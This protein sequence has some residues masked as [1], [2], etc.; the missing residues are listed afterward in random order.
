MIR[1]NI[2][3]SAHP[4]GCAAETLRQIEYVKAR[5]PRYEGLAL[6][7]AVLVIGASGGYGLASRIAAAFGCGAATVG[8]SLEREPSD[9]KT[10][11]PGWYN[12]NAFDRAAEEAGLAHRTMNLDAFSREAKAEAVKAARELGIAYDLV[13]YSLASPVRTDPSTGIMH[14]S[15]IKPIG[16]DYSGTTVDVFTGKLSNATVGPATEEECDETVK[17]MGG[18][19]WE[20]WIQALKEGG[21]LADG[22]RTVAYSYIGP[23][24]SWPIY[25]DGTLGRAKADL[26][27][28]ARR[29]TQ[30]MG[31]GTVPRVEAYVSVNKAVV[32]RASAV[33][34]VIPL[35]V[36]VLFRVMKE[37]RNHEDCIAQ[38]DRLFRERLCLVVRHADRAAQGAVPAAAAVPAPMTAAAPPPTDDE[39][40]IRMDDLEMSP[41]VQ[42]EVEAA[43]AHVT[44]ETLDSLADLEGFRNDFLS[45]H[46]FAV[47]GVDYDADVDPRA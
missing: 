37:R 2:C 47:P 26:D 39:G 33:I 5:K 3:L 43:M 27:A 8:M 38:M 34:P 17:V 45:A 22:C 40:R 4:T 31:P 42:A 15:A 24:L 9:S 23:R 13:I 29:M 10:G 36:S 14:R 41:G 35:Y 18:E 6:P 20:L 7:K 44:P 28:T 1:N 11:T 21:V 30:R 16:Q 25:R 12:N 19:D 46:G 32:T